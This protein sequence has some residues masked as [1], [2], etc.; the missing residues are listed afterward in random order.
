MGII[1]PMVIGSVATG[2][3]EFGGAHTVVA[4]ADWACSA[5]PRSASLCRPGSR[6]APR[7]RSCRGF[8]HA[9]LVAAGTAAA[10]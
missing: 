8:A 7:C 2:V 4:G 5:S 6:S 1:D 10:K 9:P 3:L